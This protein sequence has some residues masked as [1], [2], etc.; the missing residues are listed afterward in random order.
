MQPSLWLR[1]HAPIPDDRVSQYGKQRAQGVYSQ[2][3]STASARVS[4]SGRGIAS[5]CKRFALGTIR[6]VHERTAH[7]GARPAP[8]RLRARE[9]RVKVPRQRRRNSRGVLLSDSCKL[10]LAPSKGV[11][12]QEKTGRERWER[13][14][15]VEQGGKETRPADV[16]GWGRCHPALTQSSGAARVRTVVTAA[17]TA[18]DG[19]SSTSVSS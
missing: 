19:L 13:G 18:G 7:G 9:D 12:A 5:C 6:R 2:T 16:T 10:F 11:G 8:T 1:Q 3:S 17:K 4:L 15:T 14:K